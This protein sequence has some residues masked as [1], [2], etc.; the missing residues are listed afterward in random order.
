M[1]SFV[2]TGTDTG[3]GKTVFSAALAQALDAYYWNPCSLVS[4]ARRIRKPSPGYLGF[5][6]RACCPK[7]GA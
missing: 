7:N 5:H 1:T 6:R 3:V 4:T 2:I